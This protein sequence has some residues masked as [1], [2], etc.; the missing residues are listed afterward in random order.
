MGCAAVPALPQPLSTAGL[1]GRGMAQIP[2]AFKGWGHSLELVCAHSVYVL[3][4]RLIALQGDGDCGQFGFRFYFE[5]LKENL[6]S[7]N[8]RK[9]LS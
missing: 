1:P 4:L 6:K 5:S 3:A 7:S 9:I 8:L 2:L